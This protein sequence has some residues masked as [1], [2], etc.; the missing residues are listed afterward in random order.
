MAGIKRKPTMI[1]T[2]KATKL[3]KAF[4][5]S[6]GFGAGFLTTS[7]FINWSGLFIYVVFGSDAT[8]CNHTP[9]PS[10]ARQKVMQPSAGE[11]IAFFPMRALPR[12]TFTQGVAPSYG[13][14]F[15]T[16]PLQEV[17]ILPRAWT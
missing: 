9:S 4:S 16:R 8:F 1:F 2:S 14:I 6:E 17:A 15:G 10:V 3:L 7:D 11:K 12:I 13:Q 5:L